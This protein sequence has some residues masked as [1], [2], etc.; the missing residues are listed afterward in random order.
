MYS[1]YVRRRQIL[2]NHVDNFVED[3]QS[4]EMNLVDPKPAVSQETHGHSY[5]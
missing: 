4:L 2:T 1:V 5:K 3:S